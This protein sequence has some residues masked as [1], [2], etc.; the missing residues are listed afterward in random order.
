MSCGNPHLLKLANQNKP[1]V[2]ILPSPPNPN[3]LLSFHHHGSRRRT[4]SPR[5]PLLLR[6]SSLHRLRIC[7]NNANTPPSFPQQHQAGNHREPAATP[8]RT[9]S[10]PSQLR[11]AT[12]AAPQ[13]HHRDA[14]F[15]SSAKLLHSASAMAATES[16]PE[17]H[18]L[19]HDHREFFFP[20]ARQPPLQ[21]HHRVAPPRRKTAAAAVTR[22]G[23]ECES[24]T[25]I[26]ER[27]S[28]LLRVS[29]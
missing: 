22:E 1:R 29:F 20:R 9:F 12:I 10:A 27:E 8:R 4:S 15:I 18:H 13:R 11:S 6:A 28:A 2:I 26:L 16:E 24:E 21:Q 23:E 3:F 19:L 17:H 5:R 14:I 25:L 7:S